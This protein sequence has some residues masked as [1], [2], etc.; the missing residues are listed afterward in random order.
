MQ[1]GTK[2]QERRRTVA[3][4]LLQCKTHKDPRNQTLGN[5]SRRHNPEAAVSKSQS[6]EI[7]GIEAV[8]GIGN[9]SDLNILAGSR[10]SAPYVL[11]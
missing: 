6:P 11:L 7:L 1:A 5:L 3:H 8:L 2:G 9:K 4:M 10:R